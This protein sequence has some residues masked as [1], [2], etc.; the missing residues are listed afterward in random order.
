MNHAEFS[1]EAET[2]D[3][4]F[5]A[6]TG[7]T[8]ARTITNDA[9]FVVETLVRENALRE[10]RLFYQD[11][12]GQIDELAHTGKRFL[13]FHAGHSGVILPGVSE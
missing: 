12:E 10:R 3:Y 4:I 8:H 11:S 2:P 1:I 6:D 5:I 9:E 13:E 7:H